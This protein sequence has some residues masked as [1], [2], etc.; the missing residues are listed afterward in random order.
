[1]LSLHRCYLLV[2]QLP[3]NGE[4]GAADNSI[5]WQLVILQ[6]DSTLLHGLDKL[7]TLQ[8]KTLQLYLLLN[9]VC[10]C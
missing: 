8:D 4:Q 2:G 9:M 7:V 6:L 10:Q 5:D 3:A 1:M